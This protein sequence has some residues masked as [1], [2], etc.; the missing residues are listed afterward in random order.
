MKASQP[1]ILLLAGS[2]FVVRNLLLGTFAEAVSKRGPL[3]VAVLNNEDPRLQE[4]AR[5]KNI[6]LMGFPIDKNGNPGGLRQL[7]SWHTYMY[8]FK[9][10]ERANASLKMQT[11]LYEPSRSLVGRAFNQFLMGTGHLLKAAGATAHIEDRYLK[12]VEQWPIT[13]EWRQ[14]LER[15][16]PAAVVSSMLTLATMRYH[17]FDLPPMVAA[18]ALGIPGGTLI[19]SWDNLSSKT[20]VLPP[21]LERYW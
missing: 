9:A 17:S 3:L 14:L 4:L 13:L 16:Q 2:G 10:V 11:K 6:E 5:E 19:Q 1:P 7:T 15:Y 21:W 12:A 18:R 20:A 8:Q